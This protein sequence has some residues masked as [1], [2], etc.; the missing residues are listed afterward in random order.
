MNLLRPSE[1]ITTPLSLRGRRKICHYRYGACVGSGNFSIFIYLSAFH[2][3][4]IYIWMTAR[5]IVVRLISGESIGGNYR[6][7]ILQ[8]GDWKSCL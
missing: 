3:A 2:A 6:N 4:M 7:G 5:K 8:M 1:T